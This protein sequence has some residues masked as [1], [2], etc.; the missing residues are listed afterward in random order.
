MKSQDLHPGA[1][2]SPAVPALDGGSG[3]AGEAS[4]IDIDRRLRALESRFDL[5][6][7]QLDGWCAWAVLRFR[8]QSR[9]SMGA[10]VGTRAGWSRWRLVLAAQDLPRL[11]RPGRGRYLA[12]T[13]TSG[14]AERRDGLY[15]DVWF[16]D[17]L[18][19][20]GSG[21]KIE[22]VNNPGFLPRRRQ[23]RFSAAL[24]STALD[25]GAAILSRTRSGAEIGSAADM[26]SKALAAEFGSGVF[27][28]EWAN[29]QLCAFHHA[30]RMYHWL[31]G[32]IDPKIV[33]VADPGE[34]ALVAAAKERLIPVV[35][36]QHGLID[37]HH[38]GYSWTPYAEP[39]RD[40]LP[41][42]DAL[43]LFGE[44]TLRELEVNGFWGSALRTVGCPRVDRYRSLRR[45][46]PAEERYTMVVTTQGIE[47][48]S[49]IVLL[50]RLMQLLRGT[51]PFRL[52]IKLHPVYDID[53]LERYRVA[54]AGYSE[55]DVLPGSAEVSILEL[56]AR[57]HLHLSIS[58]TCHFDALALGVPTVVLPFRT[59][60][61]V[62]PLVVKGHAHLVQDA[63]D[64]AALIHTRPVRPPSDI[65][66]SY[67]RPGALAN[68]K[69]EIEELIAHSVAVGR[70]RR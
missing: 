53:T 6:R 4:P 21:F 33:L 58:S 70:D 8:V 62:L 39:Y 32:R 46:S 25:L 60:E 3:Q 57:A 15:T 23:A 56:L 68:M 5:L 54:F 49:I 63:D 43:F 55:V 9:I 52:M 48:N 7:H 26:I 27:S 18:G 11:I 61:V 45:S 50:Q 17:L 42:P 30:R 1:A 13:Y 14:L 19:F 47:T 31:L 44:H 10:V 36:I 28:P 35:E 67:Y 64:L 37:T 16:D 65:G 34:Y 22:G 51:L 59:H 20:L 38:S 12:K 69:H 66:D 29:R 40:H 2:T 41:I 24:T